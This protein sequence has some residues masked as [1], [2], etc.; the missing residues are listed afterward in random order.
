M[1]IN[2][3][4]NYFGLDLMVYTSSEEAKYHSN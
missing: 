3:N 1:M 2:V 4:Q